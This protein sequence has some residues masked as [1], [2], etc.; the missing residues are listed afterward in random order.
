M[1][2]IEAEGE[3]KRWMDCEDLEI[4]VM[5]QT[6]SEAARR[7]CSLVASFGAVNP[8]RRAARMALGAACRY[9]GL[10]M[11]K[12]L[13]EG[14]AKMIKNRDY[15]E[16]LLYEEGNLESDFEFIGRRHK[17]KM[18]PINERLRILDYLCKTA[19]KTGFDK[20]DFLFYAYF[21]D[22]SEI[23]DLLKKKRC[24]HTRNVDQDRYQGRPARSEQG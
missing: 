13:V 3:L 8:V 16:A 21:S 12:A 19:D 11:V 18:L 22:E 15:V 1:T 6:P 14:G 24:G 10:E 17:S 9:R 5:K 20:D 4:V 2:H 7:Y 23:I